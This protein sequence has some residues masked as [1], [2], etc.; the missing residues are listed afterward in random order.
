MAELPRPDL[1]GKRIEMGKQEV[2]RKV[3]ATRE[4]IGH[5][6]DGAR[7]VRCLKTVVEVVL[8]MQGNKGRRKERQQKRSREV[9]GRRRA[10]VR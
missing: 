5:D 9:H 4:S 10:V 1:G 6:I 7:N 8:M 3:P 2:V